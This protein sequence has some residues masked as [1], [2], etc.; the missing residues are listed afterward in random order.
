MKRKIFSVLFA[1]V[2]ALSSIPMTAA[3]AGASGGPITL[4]VSKWTEYATNPVFDP[5]EKAYYPTVLFDGT[6]YRMWYADETGIR[7]TTSSNGITWAAGTPA[8]GLLNVNHPL[9]KYIGGKYIIWYWDTSQLYSINAIRY[10]ESTNGTTWTSDQALTQVGTTVVA[11]AGWNRGSYGPC[12]VLYNPAGSATIVTPV[13]AASVWANK[14]VMYYDGTTGGAEAVGLAVSADGKLWQGYNGGAAAVLTG[15]GGGAWDQGYA[16]RCIVLKDGSTYH[17]LYSGGAGEVWGGIGH[18]TSADGLAWTK[19]PKNPYLHKNDGVAWR[20]N[21]TYSPAIIKDG[22]VYKMWFSGLAGGN[23]AIGYATTSYLSPDYKTI[24]AAI[25]AANPGDTINVAAGTYNETIDI[26][27]RVIL[28][29]SGSGTTGTVLQSTI[30]PTLVTGSPYSY[31]PVVIISSSG[32]GGSP[33]LLKDLMIRPRQDI[34]TGGQLPGIL[35]RPG[36]AI[37]YVELNNVRIVGTQSAGTAESGITLDD[38]T[39][40]DHL[41]VRNCEFRDMGYGIIF[42]NNSNTGTMAQNI[43]IS[44]TTFDRN[45]IKGFYAEKLSNTTFTD[46]TITNNG[47][48]TLAPFWAAPNNAGIDINLKYG[49]YANIV[50]NNLTVTGNGVGSTNGAGLTVKARGTG[51]DTGYSSRPATLSGV[52]ING[53]TFTGNEVGIRFGEP[54]KNNTKP[55]N[56]NVSI[57]SITGNTQFGLSNLVSGVTVD[58]KN[59]WW[60]NASGPTHAGNPGGTGDKVSDNVNY[61]P[62]LGV[63]AKTQTVTNG[64]VDDKT[65][66]DTEVSVTGTATVTVAEYSTNPGG[67]FSGSVGKFV[68]VHISSTVGVTQIEIR[69]YYTNAELDAAGVIESLL[70]L[71]WW[72]GASWVL[73]SD[74]GVV[75]PAGGPTYRG[76]MWARIRN[77]TTPTLA[78]LTGTPFGGGG[79]RGGGGGGEGG[80]STTG[81]TVTP[82]LLID[83]N[84]VLQV[85]CQLKTIDGRLTLYIA[86]GTKLLD[87]SGRPFTYL[88]ATP[89]PTPPPPP[90][91]DILLAYNLGL[92]GGTFSPAAT[93][94]IQ[95]DSPLP[96]NIAEKDLYIAYW[97]GSNWVA[98]KSTVDTTEHSVSCGVSHFTC[99]AVIGPLPTAAPPSITPPKVEPQGG[100]TNP[101]AKPPFNWTLVGIIAAVMMILI[102]LVVF[103]A[104]RRAY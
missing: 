2:L 78:Q 84:G 17:M 49:D 58:A 30:S 41:M 99:F 16:S 79:G 13:D 54:G 98:L 75:Y 27:H 73:C 21:R 53:G 104:R 46:V 39:N 32:I 92:S 89:G 38:N 23:Y 8:T 102:A 59:N 81:L 36:S 42:F 50:F 3:P 74:S 66:A 101:E 85:N 80:P 55:T 25:T 10:A 90:G 91:A 14:F 62:W 1:L 45:S 56:I 65:E 83:E 33:I 68:D 57:A 69:V 34:V 9:V 103:L 28:Q 67:S 87:S 6:T 82:P 43:E 97:D 95:Y 15:G 86:K 72:D 64:T 4:Y 18:A 12:D 48:T 24:Q 5:A 60:G 100:T 70:T 22:S 11:P 93:L 71:R 37:S 76:Y 52:T 94:T 63:A 19:D 44:N 35:P 96:D 40:L 20:A 31:K 88:A 7:Y 61:T 29:G 26:T 77:D 51:S 47:N